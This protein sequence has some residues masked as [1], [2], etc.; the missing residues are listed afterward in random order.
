MHFL[1]VLIAFMLYQGQL[2]EYTA[3]LVNSLT[4]LVKSTGAGAKVFALLARSPRKR[5]HLG[6]HPRDH[7]PNPSGDGGGSGGGTRR[8]NGKASS[9][10]QRQQQ[11]SPLLAAATVGSKDE[12]SIL[13]EAYD[14]DDAY[15][16]DGGSDNDSSGDDSSSSDDE[17]GDTGNNSNSH[18]QN[19]ANS[20]SLLPA[21][22]SH[23]NSG[24]NINSS[25]SS[26]NNIPSLSL[27]LPVDSTL[28]LSLPPVATNAAGGAM[29]LSLNNVWF[30]Y[31][32]RPREPV[33]RGLTISAQP[34]QTAALVGSSGSGKS[35]VLH[36]LTRLYEPATG[37]VM[38]RG[39][40]FLLIVVERSFSS[41]ISHALSMYFKFFYSCLLTLISYTVQR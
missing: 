18:L 40:V 11:Q 23:G 27:S 10:R 9:S 32:S 29:S 5:P 26:N 35:T 30:A 17:G 22:S 16:N 31:P 6:F 15:A 28:P 25:S 34:G 37:N 8:S 36:L 14:E 24:D 39:S 12:W 2:Q 21:D 4:N 7:G 41:P 13:E 3:N 33:L 19:H 1:Q 38:V 20:A